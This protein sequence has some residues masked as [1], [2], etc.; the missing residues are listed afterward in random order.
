MTTVVAGV[1]SFPAYYLFC[2]LISVSLVRLLLVVS[3]L[4]D[5]G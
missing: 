1:S 4:D 2:V 3:G 5:P